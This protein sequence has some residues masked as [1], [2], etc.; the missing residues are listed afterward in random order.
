MDKYARSDPPSQTAFPV[1]RAGYPFIFVAAFT[2]AILALLGLTALTLLGLVLTFCICGFFRDPDRFIPV[3]K[4]A[5][6]SPADGKVIVARALPE[7]PLEAGPCYQISVFMTVFNV[8]VNRVPHSGRVDNIV[9]TPGSFV[10]AD[11]A[12]AS[13]HN[14]NNAVRICTP[15]GWSYWVVQ[16]AGLVARRIICHLT[17]GDNVETGGRLSRAGRF[18]HADAHPGPTPHAGA[19]RWVRVHA[20]VGLHPGVERVV[21]GFAARH[22]RG[23]G[24]LVGVE[25]LHLLGDL[26]Q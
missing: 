6:V 22:Q 8:H 9:Y 18:E 19:T 12:K 1:A 16:I 20:R 10:P 14:E 7:G 17:P 2:T 23:D 21:L 24:R 25:G 3:A 4:G 11:R 15:E 13:T 26:P 5:V